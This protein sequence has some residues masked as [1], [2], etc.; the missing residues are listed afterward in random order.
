MFDPVVVIPVFDHPA[1]IGTVARQVRAHGLRCI[2]VDDGSAAPCA[3]VLDALAADHP[4]EL[5]LLRLTSNQGKGA[6]MVAGFR[7]AARRGHSHVLQ[8]DADGQHACADIPSF[9][10]RARAHPNAV[11]AGCPIYD[12]SVPRARLYGRYATHVWVWINTLSLD[13][14]DSMCGFRVYPLASLVPL[15]DAVRIG[16]RMDF[17]SD[18]IVRLHWRGVPVLNQPTRVRYPQDGVSH[19]RMGRDNLRISAMHA[20]LFLGMLLRAPLLIWRKVASP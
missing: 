19:F 13:I 17:D 12:D 14:R 10:E 11:I 18:I 9:I 3:A 8:I 6:A 15:L 2:L 5:T 20:R 1:T 7:E 4:H 16:R